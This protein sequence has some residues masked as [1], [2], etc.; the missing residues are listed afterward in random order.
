MYF[1]VMCHVCKPGISGAE[2]NPNINISHTHKESGGKFD[3][4]QSQR[5]SC[6][7]KHLKSVEQ[8]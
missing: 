3:L 2:S 1:G 4:G 6:G 7:E 8:N 5:D